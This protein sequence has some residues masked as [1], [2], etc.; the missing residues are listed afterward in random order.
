MRALF[1][2]QQLWYFLFLFCV[3]S[4]ITTSIHY[5]EDID[6]LRFAYSVVDEYNILKLQPHFPGYAVFCF[7]ANILYLI[8]GNMGVV[9][10]IIGGISIFIIIYYS[11][12]LMKID[13]DS[14]TGI[15]VSLLI[16][17][18]PMF[19]I[20]SNRYMPDLMGLSVFIVSF[21]FLS[22]KN[23][24]SIVIGLLL[25]GILAGIRISYL[26]LLFIPVLFIL[27]NNKFNVKFYFAIFL[28][29]VIWLLPMILITGLSDLINMGLKHTTG[30]F[31]DY[32]GTVLTETNWLLRLQY[33]FH[34]IWADGL[35]GYWS[36]RSFI[37]IILSILLIP[38]LIQLIKNIQFLFK[39]NYSFKILF[40]STIV[41]IIW[42]LLFQ[43]IIYKS[44]HVMPLI[45]VLIIF[46]S[47]S[48]KNNF[49]IY[50]NVKKIYF[51]LVIILTAYISINLSI[52]HKQPTAIKKIS[53]YLISKEKP[54]M[55]ISIPLINYY[56]KSQNVNANYID[57]ENNNEKVTLDLLDKNVFVIGDFSEK[58]N[59]L[60]T[61]LDT[62][63]YHNPYVNRMW[64]D[65]NIYS[66]KNL[67]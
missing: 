31:T 51:S 59:G 48:L 12:R 53:Q 41:Y 24:R 52:Q 50:T 64:S 14:I 4:R 43:N 38:L 23:E 21:Y 29:I 67:K 33:F 5:I 20:M 10:S 2:S 28:G 13:I 65:I 8:I 57:L 35:G 49:L 19:W 26:P 15:F 60:S 58:I 61:Q 34:T 40:I 66:N 37:T 1:S 55:I 6:S 32:G 56:L 18:N 63:F 7:I 42:I 46:F 9:F 16:F 45:L 27:I 39:D 30:H 25:T 36:N 17:F 22:H 3:L 54:I 47:S 62:T 44:R 11:L